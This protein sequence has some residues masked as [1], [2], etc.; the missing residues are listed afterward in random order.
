MFR[1]KNPYKTIIPAQPDWYWVR[2][3]W[4][5]ARNPE[6]PLMTTVAVWALTNDGE[7]IGLGGALA[8]FDDTGIHTQLQPPWR[9][10]K[11][12]YKHLQDFEPHERAFYDRQIKKPRPL[13]I[14]G[15]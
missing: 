4:S 1:K 15:F 5:Q 2:A 8:L 14:S 13:P 12:V 3:D 10:V 11:G 9:S 7:V 6:Y